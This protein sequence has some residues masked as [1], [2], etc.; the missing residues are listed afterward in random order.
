MPRP[1]LPPSRSVRRLALHLAVPA[2]GLLLLTG[3]FSGSTGSAQDA[4]PT[5]GASA[6]TGDARIRIA[7][8]QPPRSGF[9]P[10]TDDAFKMARWS[11]IEPLVVL[12]DNGDAQPLLATAWSQVD[13]TTW[14]FEIRQGVTFHDG[15][16]LTTDAVVASL[17]A[18]AAASPPPRILDGVQLTAQVDPAAPQEAV[19][20]RTAA[21]D[22]LLPQRLSSPQLSIMSPAAYPSGG[23]QVNPVRHGTGPFVLT[24]VNGT[25]SATL[26]RFDGYWGTKAAAS[27]IDASFVPDGTARAAA[28]RTGTAD[29]VEAVPAGQASLLDPALLHEVQMPRTNTL[30]LNTASG[31]FADPAA[32]AA[33]RAAVDAQTIVDVVYEGRADVAKGLLGPALPWSAD[34]PQRT[35]AAAPAGGGNGRV[36]TL[37]TFT[38]RAELPEVA[39]QLQ[40]QLEAAGFVVQ[41]DVREYAQIE[42]DAL[43]GKFDAFI[44]SRATVLDSGDPVAYL[45]SDFSCAGSFNISQFCDPAVD[46][47]IAAAS[48]T[49][50]GPQRRAAVLAA[51]KLI[52]EADAAVP[53]LHERVLQGEQPG[54]T[55]AARDPRERALVTPSTTVGAA[56]S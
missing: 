2:A 52:L 36:I 35:Q 45:A 30:Y 11:N 15:Q 14:R 44:L 13:P 56:S 40:A 53:M 7:H 50:A 39:V 19:L 16:P 29:I 47:A 49:P 24:A 38:D 31:V 9:S 1:A 33:A 48:S 23:G 51:E 18:A 37:G 22:P 26:D 42:A 6:G 20:V 55:D 34:R 21:A 28:L 8:L 12:D 46:A 41:Q 5:A 25:S 32:R 27:G 10:L 4:A 54:V 3:C 43:S 17:T